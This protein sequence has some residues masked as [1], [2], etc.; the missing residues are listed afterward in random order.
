MKKPVVRK[1]IEGRSVGR[2]TKKMTSAKVPRAKAARL[3]GE[4]LVNG[5]VVDSEVYR[6]NCACA[7]RFFVL[8]CSL[9]HTF[10]VWRNAE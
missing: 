2:P 8:F 5:E 9:P 10:C 3:T 4:L 7:P 6:S 1:K